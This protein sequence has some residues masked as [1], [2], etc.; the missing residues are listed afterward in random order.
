MF[1]EE[2]TSGGN[3][4]KSRLGEWWGRGIYQDCSALR[5]FHMLLAADRSVCMCVYVCFGGFLF[6]TESFLLFFLF[7][8]A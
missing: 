6:P 4:E 3:G 8:E 1:W 2:P 5:G 7:S